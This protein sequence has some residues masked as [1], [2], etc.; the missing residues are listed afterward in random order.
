MDN[1][2][3]QLRRMPQRPANGL[4][5]W[6]ATVGYISAEYNTDTTL[7]LKATPGDEAT[8]W[9]AAI[10]W[11]DIQAQVADADTLP[12][13]LRDLWLELDKTTTVFK[14]PQD[15]VR[16]PALYQEQQWIDGDTAR[17][18]ESLIEVTGGV[19]QH[20][21]LLMVIYRAVES[22]AQRVK[23]RLIA[24]DSSVQIGGQGPSLRE[25]CRDLYRNAA[26]GYF[27]S[28]G[29]TVDAVLL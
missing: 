18:L 17:A 7:T 19:F 10:S 8:K 16:Q 3:I 23:M 21:W 24:K 6:Q 15:A 20:D 4:L 13:A 29:R 11:G 27:A 26:P 28:S 14:T 5:A 22:P 2:T 25:A 9:H 1:K 12:I